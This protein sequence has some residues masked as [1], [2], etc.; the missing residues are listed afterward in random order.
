MLPSFGQNKNKA[1]SFLFFKFRH[2][3][4]NYWLP[5]KTLMD[6]F[7]IW[8]FIS[9]FTK[10]KYLAAKTSGSPRSVY[11]K[12]MIKKKKP[13]FKTTVNL[14]MKNNFKRFNAR[15]ISSS[16]Q[17]FKKYISGR[18]KLKL[19]REYFLPRPRSKN[20]KKA[21][22]ILLLVVQNTLF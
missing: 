21:F 14:Q 11:T 9:V 12:V 19:S 1:S 6:N 17:I 16:I 7:Q 5:Y 4:S 2:I 18:K 10:H 22:S 15:L 13:S 8:A 20:M 3:Y